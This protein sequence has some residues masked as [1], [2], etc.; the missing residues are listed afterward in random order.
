MEF[1]LNFQLYMMVHVEKMI[2]NRFLVHS[3]QIKNKIFLWLPDALV[4]TGGLNV[5][6]RIIL[7]MYGHGKWQE[8]TKGQNFH[9]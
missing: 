2:D 8:V 9:F 5:I 3:M 7:H 4:W 6:F 1:K